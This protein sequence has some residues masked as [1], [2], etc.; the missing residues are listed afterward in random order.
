MGLE[1]KPRANLQSPQYNEFDYGVVIDQKSRWEKSPQQKWKT[2]VTKAA[3]IRN[4]E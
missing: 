4:K 1:N 2:S 3:K